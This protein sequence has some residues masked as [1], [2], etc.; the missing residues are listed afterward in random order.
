M[1]KTILL[2]KCLVGNLSNLTLGEC[3]FLMNTMWADFS[4][5]EAQK[6]LKM[7]SD[8]FTIC[9]N[10]VREQDPGSFNQVLLQVF[11]LIT[12]DPSNLQQPNL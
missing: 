10:V 9:A 3:K 7:M 8:I 12:S 6:I 4:N 11:S 2:K 5:Q 1:T